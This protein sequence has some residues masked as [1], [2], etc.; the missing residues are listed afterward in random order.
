MWAER[1]REQRQAVK[2]SMEPVESH[3]SWH[4]KK[5]QGKKQQGDKAAHRLHHG[6]LECQAT[7][8]DVPG[9]AMENCGGREG[10]V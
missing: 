3:E 5:K 10:V 4:K 9:E 8:S 6:V 2:N 1:M 7:A